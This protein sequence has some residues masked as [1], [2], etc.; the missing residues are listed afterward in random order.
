MPSRRV[1]IRK[2]T[3]KDLASVETWLRKE[4]EETG[5][6]FYCNLAVIA[7]A[8]KREDL[9][10]LAVNGEVL[11]FVADAPLGA[12]IVEVR[13]D[14]RGK[15]YGRKLAEW[16]INAT[17][18]RGN[19]VMQGECAPKSSAPFWEK[20]GFTIV[21]GRGSASGGIY[22]Y[23]LLQRQFNLN[24]GPRVPFEIA[25]HT[26]TRSWDKSTKPFREYVGDAELLNDKSLQLPERAICFAPEISNL[27]DC[28]VRISVNGCELF[29]N[30]VKRPEAKSLGVCM[31]RGGIY[32]LDRIFP[33]K[34]SPEL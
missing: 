15:G 2:A 25:F 1:T 27:A 3:R 26:A 22:A 23:K 21:H 34:E 29:E 33:L 10:V 6:G 4:R 24:G 5:G 30:K 18:R 32:I 7:N 20:M 31:D 12:D 19:S 13:T 8:F 14:A 17:Y 28:V 16:A 9:A 11:G